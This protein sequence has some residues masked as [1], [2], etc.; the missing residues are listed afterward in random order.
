MTASVIA[1]PTPKEI[2]NFL[3]GSARVNQLVGNL[4]N[5]GWKAGDKQIKIIQSEFNELVAGLADRDLYELRDGIGDLF[6]TLA[7]IAHRMGINMVAD[8]VHVVESQYT[9]FDV[10]YEEWLKTKAKYDAIGME[11]RF[12]VCT[13]PGDEETP[14]R[15]YW[16]TFSAVEQMDEKGRVCPEGKWLKSY[17]TKEATYPD[18]PEAVVE[19]LNATLETT[20]P[21]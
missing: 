14:P 12:E 17:K 19:K 15:D 13:D 21:A 10:S 5:Q 8:Y 2:A 11:V 6:F 3:T 9:K 20:Q 18:L 1:K 4:E 7:G 16:V